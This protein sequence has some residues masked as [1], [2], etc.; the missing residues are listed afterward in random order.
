[1]TEQLRLERGL[2]A[3]NAWRIV[4]VLTLAN[5]LNFYDRAVPAIVVEPVKA[6][7]GLSDTAV[8]IISGGFTVVYAIAGIALGRMADRGSR[9]KIMA[10][11]LVAWS[12]FT[13]ASGGAWS[14]A[15]ILIFRLAV[16]IGEAS[17]APAAN[18]MIADL[19]PATKRSRAVA[20]FQ[21]GLPLGLTAA[22]FTTGAIVEAFGSWRAPFFIAAIPGFLVAVALLT[23]KEPERG[24]SEELPVGASVALRPIRAILQI[25]TMWWLALSGIGVQVA[26]YAA[27][28]FIV[29]LFQRYFGLSLIQAASNTGV[30]LGLTG[31]VGLTVGGIIAD[32]AASHRRRGRLVVAAVGLTL[33]VPLTWW[34]L[35]LPP[36]AVG[37]FI[38]LFAAGWLLQFS[39]AVS[40]LP[41]VADVVEPRLRSTGV[42]LL[43]AAFY[44]FGGAFGPVIA[45]ALSDQFAASATN[46]PAGLTAEAVGLHASLHVL[47][48][49]ALVI[50]AIGLIGSIWTVDRDY[51]RMK[52]SMGAPTSS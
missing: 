15:S 14:F 50:A 6:E 18:S 22:F 4:F 52:E 9:R 7:F 35:T 5:F 41:A 3:P 13:A 20:V 8:G 26:A 19:F 1:V 45:G 12:V 17:Y 30:I 16:G 29:P 27:A 46:L 24:A 21:F 33:S 10:W 25:P 40:A 48:P 42:A 28:T 32:R 39:F 37:L 43:L 51:T 44:L 47:I 38:V 11:G 36:A 49:I 34:A 2:Q 31:L 23:I